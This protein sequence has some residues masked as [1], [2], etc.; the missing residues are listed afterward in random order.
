M[1][2]DSTVIKLE[3]NITTK[4]NNKPSN[5]E[6]VQY[7]RPCQA[8]LNSR[9]RATQLDRQLLPGYFGLPYAWH[10]KQHLTKTP[11]TNR[12]IIT[13]AATS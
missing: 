5:L 2:E 6:L 10:Q 3:T 4:A 9:N 11:G 13:L 1:I 12:E 8:W 7:I